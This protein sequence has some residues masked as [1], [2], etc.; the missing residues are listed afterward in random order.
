[1]RELKVGDRVRIYRIRDGAMA[2]P[3][4]TDETVRSICSDSVQ[5][6]RAGEPIG[7]NS[8]W[9]RKQVRLLKPKRKPREFLV[10]IQAS[11]GRPISI[12]QSFIEVGV[13]LSNEMILVREVLPRK[14]KP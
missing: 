13:N 12:T 10:E 6:M 5:T 2:T 14:V 4:Y 3:V 1:M 9:H 8:W 11:T 7:A